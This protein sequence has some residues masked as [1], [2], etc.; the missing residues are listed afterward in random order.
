M[1]DRPEANGLESTAELLSLVRG[2]DSDARERL[3]ERFLPILR[4]WARGRLPQAARDLSDTDDLV[5]VALLRALDRVGEFEP[6][7]EGAFLAYLR[8]IVLNS[9]RDEL[10]RAGRRPGREPLSPG[11][12]AEGPSLLE[13]AIGAEMVEAYEAALATLPQE[14]QEAVIMR[15]EFGY[16]YPEIATAQGKPTANAARM[17]VS[18]ALVRLAEVMDV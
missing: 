6:R 13:Q 11:L 4:R 12:E 5:Q 8:R 10:R 2:G 15:I 14:Q 7:H 16:T 17:A 9:V 18:R 3:V 1:S